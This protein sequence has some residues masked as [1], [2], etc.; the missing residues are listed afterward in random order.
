MTSVLVID[1]QPDV[2]AALGALV[3]GEPGLELV[4]SGGDAEEAIALAAL[5][6]PDVALV[7]FKMPGGG[8]AAVRGI[9]ARSPATRVIA[10]SAYGDRSSVQAML[11]AGAMGYV[12]KGSSVEEVRSAIQL[13][14]R[15]QAPLSSEV[16]SEVLKDL[17]ERLHAEARADERSHE[18]SRRIE[19]A[20]EPGGVEPVFQPVVELQGAR[21]LLGYESLARF[22][23]EPDRPVE[24]WFEAAAAVGL[25]VELE[26][27]AMRATGERLLLL[28]PDVRIGINLSPAAVLDDRI[29]DT[30]ESLGPQTT[31]LELTEHAE[32]AEYDE[33][34]RRL[35]EFKARGHRISIDD[36][37]AGFAS[38]RHILRLAPDSIKIDRSVAG[39]VADDPASR[40]VVRALV[41]FADELGIDVIAE[42]VE[43][44]AAAGVLHELG[45]RYG[46]GH[47]FGRPRP[48][49]AIRAAEPAA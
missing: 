39:H 13:A 22:P 48:A 33:L 4:G 20:L 2:R 25:G 18:A 28:P 32:V 7:D 19:L 26:L 29:V 41:S 35:A 36:V 14:L 11:R 45:V 42:G 21:K 15:D 3:E 5:H 23:A 34:A 12:V 49:E 6:R 17:T 8:P 44:A 24:Q 10:V 38:L 47:Y 43:S 40:A 1:D 30:F 46:Q 9:R 31:V 37:G 16:R 27:A